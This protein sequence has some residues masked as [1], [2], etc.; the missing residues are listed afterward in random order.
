MSNTDLA[1]LALEVS[2]RLERNKSRDGWIFVTAM[3]FLISFPIASEL[4]ILILDSASIPEERSR[5]LFGDDRTINDSNATGFDMSRS[6]IAIGTQL[7]A[8]LISPKPSMYA[9]P[10]QKRLGIVFPLGR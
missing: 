10:S 7:I 2:P 3:W 1:V 9:L 5:S 6:L 8:P 4:Y